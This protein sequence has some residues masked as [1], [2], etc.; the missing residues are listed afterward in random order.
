MHVY[1][2]IETCFLAGAL[3]H[4]RKPGSRKR[5]TTLSYEHLPAIGPV[6]PQL[7][8]R[9]D[10]VTT[11]RVRR[12]HAVLL[13]A[14]VNQSGAKVDLVPAQLTQFR[15]PEPVTGSH[16]DRQRVA[17]T[18]PT[19]APRCLG[20]RLDLG[21]RQVLALPHLYVLRP[22][23][24]APIRGHCPQNMLRGRYH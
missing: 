11:E 8:Q 12:W 3:D 14:Y 18:L 17:M 23:D 20:K 10:L 13:P 4:L 7:P 2:K 16:S 5:R 9:P 6:P 1:R 24:P 15:H 19:T 21:G 22:S